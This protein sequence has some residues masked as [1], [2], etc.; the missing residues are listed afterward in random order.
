MPIW[1]FVSKR[2]ARKAQKGLINEKQGLSS[3]GPW[4]DSRSDRLRSF[5]ITAGCIVRINLLFWDHLLNGYVEFRLL[6]LFIPFILF[7]VF[8]FIVL[9]LAGTRTHEV[10]NPG[11]DA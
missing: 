3:R 1:S 7:G 5:H 8:I 10:G 2:D 6:V 4:S 9:I 11:F